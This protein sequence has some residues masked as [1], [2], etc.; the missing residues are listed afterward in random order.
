MH[1]HAHGMAPLVVLNLL[2]HRGYGTDL[3]YARE[4]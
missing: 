1:H 3:G 2:A 4:I